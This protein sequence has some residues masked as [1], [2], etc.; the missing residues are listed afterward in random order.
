MKQGTKF[1][2]TVSIGVNLDEIEAIKFKF[3]QGTTSLV[4]NYPEGEN[5][6]R[7]ENENAVNLTW[8]IEDTFLFDTAVPVYMDSFIKLT[9][10]NLNPDTEI[11][12]LI[13]EKTL[14]K[15]EELND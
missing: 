15:A 3:A 1:A 11:K 2:L 7:V 14:F 13:L 6:A 8:T 10:S 4:F 9:G 5:T 12:T